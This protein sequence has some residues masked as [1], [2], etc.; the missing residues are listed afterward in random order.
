LNEGRV[1]K[2]KTLLSILAV[3][4]LFWAP[5]TAA[6]KVIPDAEASLYAGESV[7]VKGIIA[8]V[9]QSNKGNIFLNFGSPYPNQTLYAVIF[10][11]DAAK[12][13][14]VKAYEGK[15]VIVTGVVQSYKGKAEI[16]L[17]DPG[18]IKLSK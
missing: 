1:V 2:V 6:E 9:F 7:A 11:K 17:K 14:N 3:S 5:V 4:L 12:F 10:G 15:T 18:Q 16:I 8:N 13:G